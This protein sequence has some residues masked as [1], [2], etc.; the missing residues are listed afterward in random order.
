MPGRTT[1]DVLLY[2]DTRPVTNAI[3]PVT[4]AGVDTRASRSVNRSIPCVRS[5]TP[6]STVTPHTINTTFHGIRLIVSFSSAAPASDRIVAPVSAA[7]PTCMSNAT[8]TT[9]NDARTAI[10]NQ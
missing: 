7:I 9:T 5:S 2:T 8:T 10:V 1:P 3:T 4:V 6:M